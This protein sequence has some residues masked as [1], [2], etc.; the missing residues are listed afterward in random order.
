MIVLNVHL[1][2]LYAFKNF[3]ANFTYPKKIV[4]STIEDETLP[5]RENFRYKKVNI[6][7]GANA[8]GKTTFGRIL[9]KIFNFIEKK[10]SVC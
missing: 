5:N 3:N 4:G 9:M 1:D 2:N 10:T 8:S 7:F 6:F